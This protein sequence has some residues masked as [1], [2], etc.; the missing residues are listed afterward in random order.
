MPQT[1]TTY[2]TIR[3]DDGAGGLVSSWQAIETLRCRVG[4]PAPSN[5]RTSTLKG[6]QPRT[7][8]VRKAFFQAGA[9]VVLGDR[10][11]FQ[12]E[13][14]EIVAAAD[15]S[16]GCYRLALIARIAWLPGEE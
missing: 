16:D 1:A 14:Y 9:D 11:A 7:E 8:P 5:L 13:G 3:T 10:L 4:D 2:R 12:G 15:Q 6:D